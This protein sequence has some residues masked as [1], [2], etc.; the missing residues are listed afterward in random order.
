M[1]EERKN[2][3]KGEKLINEREKKNQKE[4][5]ISFPSISVPCPQKQLRQLAKIPTT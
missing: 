2:Y 1:E 4:V 5:F 3:Y